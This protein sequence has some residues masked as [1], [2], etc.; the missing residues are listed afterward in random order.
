VESAIR[1]ALA[2]TLAGAGL[3][4]SNPNHVLSA[5]VID[6]KHIGRGVING[7]ECEQ[8]TRRRLTNG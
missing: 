7:V 6:V 2:V 4:V 8:S 3:F 5:D 1:L